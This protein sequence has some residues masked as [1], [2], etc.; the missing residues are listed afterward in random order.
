MI[1]VELA[2]SLRSYSDQLDPVLVSGANVHEALK[3]IA[4]VY[5]KLYRCICDETGA[6]RRHINL[7]VNRKIVATHR[8]SG[9]KTRLDSGDTLTIWT[10]VSGG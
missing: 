8:E 2:N 3:S 1:T 6:V 5:P 7:F 10:A 9:L 4:D